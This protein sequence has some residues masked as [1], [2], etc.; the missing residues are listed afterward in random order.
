MKMTA[1]SLSAF[2]QTTRR[3]PVHRHGRFASAARRLLVLGGT[4]LVTGLAINEMRL[5]LN[6]GG[7]TVL[8]IVVLVLF[9]INTVWIALPS[10]TGLVGFFL[11]LF[12]SV[13]FVPS[14]FPS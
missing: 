4:S 5:V 1:Q 6:V 3:V 14:H 10:L 8:E 13:L 2:D 9:A 7:L 12:R 11:L